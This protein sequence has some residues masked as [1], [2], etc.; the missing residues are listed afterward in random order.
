MSSIP[1]TF[2]LTPQ[3]PIPPNWNFADLQERLGDIPA[4]RIRLNPPPGYATEDD[5]LGIDARE[6]VLCELE[7]GILVE[8]P[9]G[10][11]ES[12]LAT[13]VST[14]LNIFLRQHRLG[15]VLGADGTLKILPGVIKIPDVSFISWSRF[16]AEKLPR[17]LIPSLI[18]DLVVEIL[19]ESNTKKEM[20]TKLVRY[21]E[22][23]VKLVWYIDPETRS[24]TAYRGI[25]QSTEVLPTGQLEGGDL[26]PGF[27]LS[28]QW[29]FEQADRQGPE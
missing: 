24:A 26:L 27:E 16:P 5:L 28:L 22:A 12:L 4:Q 13:L 7:D 19:S 9:M 10:W 17:R 20:A 15:Q 8:K 3:I 6:G 11:Y 2:H 23:G 1:D 18:P 14:E 25:D 29:L 21:F